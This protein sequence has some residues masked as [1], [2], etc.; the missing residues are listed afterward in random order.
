ML[1][2]IGLSAG[3]IV[4][5]R[6]G[7]ESAGRLVYYAWWFLALQGL[8]AVNLAMSLAD[9]FPWTKK[10]IGFVVVHASLLLIFVGSAITYFFKV[11]GSLAMWEGES[12]SIIETHDPEGRVLSGHRLPFSVKLD[13]FVLDTY[14]G[15]TRPA[16]FASHVQ[17]TDLDSGRTFPAKVWMNPELNHRGYALFQSSYEQSMGREA[18]VLSVSKDPGQTI[19]FAGFITLILGMIIVLGIRMSHSRERAANGVKAGTKAHWEVFPETT[20]E[21]LV[22]LMQGPRPAGWSTTE[23]ID[24]EV[25]YN[26]LNPVRLSWI[27]LLAS[28]LAS[29]AAWQRRSRALDRVAFGLLAGGFAISPRSRPSS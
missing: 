28:L 13:D 25:F 9:L 19:V 11:E 24:R 8:F 15:T 27:I 5:T 2:L 14:P 18:T 23:T 12:G 10:R 20:A 21:G 6:S 3:T 26:G 22:Q 17:I 4:E 1:L 29:I 7:A 16:G